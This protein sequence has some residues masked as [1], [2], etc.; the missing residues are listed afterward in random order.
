MAVHDNGE[1]LVHFRK[2]LSLGIVAV[3]YHI[4]SKNSSCRERLLSLQALNWSH[5][6]ERAQALAT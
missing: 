3:Y 1:T 4:K 6:N 2:I 5:F